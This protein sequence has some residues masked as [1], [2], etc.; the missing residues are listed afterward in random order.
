M[1][2]PP[3]QPVGDRLGRNSGDMGMMAPGAE[4]RLIIISRYSSIELNIP[5]RIQFTIV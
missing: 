4:G 2:E 1:A 5:L 3:A